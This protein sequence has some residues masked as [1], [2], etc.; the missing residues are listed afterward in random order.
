LYQF[1]LFYTHKEHL[2]LFGSLALLF[3]LLFVY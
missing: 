2:P 3:F 1:D